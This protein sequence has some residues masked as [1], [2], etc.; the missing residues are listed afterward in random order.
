MSPKVVDK[1]Q[2][3]RELAL[4]AFDVFVEKGFDKLS[5][6][7]VARAAGI[8]KGTIYEYFDSKEELVL[9]AIAAWTELLGEGAEQMLDPDHSAEERLRTLCAGT[10]HAFMS[11]TK[12]LR[13]FLSSMNL[14]LFNER[15][16]ELNM[17]KAIY[18]R[19]GE[20][21]TGIILEGVSDGSFRPEVARDADKIAVNLFT[22]LDGIGLHWML[23]PT[24]F[25]LHD[26]IELYLEHLFA[27]LRAPT[28]ERDA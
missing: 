3:Q 22:Y 15:F 24:N 9:E 8:G 28:G 20:V 4:V 2:R 1:E 11:D 16:K 19:F 17:W 27:S 7:D 6:S 12:I 13:A 26:Q 25:D 14:M 18:A 23:N 21:I 5:I 10:M